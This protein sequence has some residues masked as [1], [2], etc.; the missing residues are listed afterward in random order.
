LDWLISRTEDSNGYSAPRDIIDMIKSAIS[1]QI[2][3]LEIGDNELEGDLLLSRKSLKDSLPLVSKEKVEKYLFAEHPSL[4]DKIE[5][6]RGQKTRQTLESLCNLWG[7]SEVEA[8][9][10]ADQIAKAGVWKKEGQNPPEYWTFFLFRDGL[11]MVQG[12]AE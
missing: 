3:L 8:E 4:R 7:V 12:T 10:V 9:A 6:L 5:K 2:H 11:D 1:L